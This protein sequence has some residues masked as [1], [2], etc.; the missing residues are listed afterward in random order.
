M[1][2][3]YN[4]Q[5]HSNIENCSYIKTTDN[6]AGYCTGL[7]NIKNHSNQNRFLIDPEILYKKVDIWNLKLA[8]NRLTS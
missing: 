7:R 8:I 4:I 2:R 5:R 6:I 3:V 1:H